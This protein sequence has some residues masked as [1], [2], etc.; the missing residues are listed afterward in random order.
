MHVLFVLFFLCHVSTFVYLYGSWVQLIMPQFWALRKYN[1]NCNGL[2]AMVAMGLLRK[3][4][5][6][7]TGP[8]HESSRR[9]LF[10]LFNYIYIYIY[11]YIL[12]FYFYF[13]VKYILE[14]SKFKTLWK[15]YFGSNFAPSILWKCRIFEFLFWK[16]LSENQVLK[17]KKSGTYIE[18][19]G[20]RFLALTSWS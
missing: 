14:Y 16:I 5:I 13:F 11:I 18:F 17:G 12:Y 1:H 15:L 19:K 3:P 6:I 20:T 8:P 7:N 4:S 9:F 2:L 10:R